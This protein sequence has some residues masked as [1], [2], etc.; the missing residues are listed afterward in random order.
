MPIDSS[1][2]DAYR[3]GTC[4]I[5]PT[6]RTARIVNALRAEVDPE[7]QQSCGAHITL[8]QPFRVAPDAAAWSTIEAVARQTAPFMVRS[9]PVERFG[10][11]CVVKLDIE[12]KAVILALRHRLHDTG[13]FD[14][15]LPH[16]DGFVPHMTL[17]EFGFSC[18]TE[19]SD[20]AVQ[21]NHRVQLDAF[22][23]IQFEFI[24]PDSE[25]RFVRHRG[26]G[27]G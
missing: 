1:W 5:F 7:S 6:G 8:T 11:S 10:T 4:V 25:F 13:L 16:T 12:P 24:K 27:L 2:R 26:V 15:T 3:H 19:A 22:E 17:S 9:G 21:I 18:P 14:L 20:W 23:C